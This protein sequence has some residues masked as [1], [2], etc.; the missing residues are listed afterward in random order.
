M[1]QRSKTA[2][3]VAALL[4]LSLFFGASAAM[5]GTITGWNTSNVTL[6]PGPYIEWN[7]YKNPVYTNSLKTTTN[8]YLSW[9]E[10][11]VK[12]PGMKVVN[13]D[14]VTGLRCIMTTGFNPFDGTDKMCSDPLQSSKR[15]KIG[16]TNGQPIDIYFN[17][18]TDTLTTYY[19]SL[20]KLTNADVRK[21]KGFKAQ[22]G[23][24]VNGVFTPSKSLDGLG[25][26]TNKGKYFTTTT[27]AVQSAEVLSA[28]FAQGLAG[29]T[30]INH[31]T[32]GYFDPANR[33]G[34]FLTATE[35][36]IDSGAL[37]SNYFA[38]FGDW[39]NL[40]GV[41]YG[42]YYDND[43]I[44]YTDNLLMANCDGTFDAV[45]GTC[46]GTWVTYRS[47]A[48]LD[49]KTGLP[50]PSDGVKKAVP[51]DILAMW[52]SNV[53]YAPASLEDLANLGLNYYV[54]IN[55]NSAKWP[56]PT[57]FVLRFTPKF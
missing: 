34:Y 9:K 12:S 1:S 56:T 26:S 20:Q 36:T 51:A 49:P 19:N 21:W 40:S 37:T 46:K 27:T 54:T 39:N 50:Y 25:F 57:Q 13:R 6:V 3:K 2:T 17:V 7:T 33:M 38:L 41:P 43:A 32:T 55:K 53:L 14:D 31:P 28:L 22:L 23:F 24:M 44:P 16:G 48:G 4:G 10:S 5:A 52:E 18:A 35:D 29:P 15:W 47:Q 8:G 30:D 42:Y 45:T 11:D